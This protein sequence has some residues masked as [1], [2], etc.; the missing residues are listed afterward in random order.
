M[1][2]TNTPPA[3]NVT[4]S[5]AA[6]Q[7]AVLTALGTLTD[8]DGLGPLSWNWQRQTGS[9]WA[10]VDGA[11]D[12]TYA[13][14][15]ADV[16]HAVRAIASYTD[17][18]GTA[19]AVTSDPTAVVANVNDAPTGEVA[20]S[21]T[22][23]L[24]GS[25]LS[26][27]A[28]LQ[29]TDGLGPITFV[30]Q[31]SDDAGGWTTIVAAA[32]PNYTPVQADV[33][34]SLRVLATY[35]DGQG[36]AESVASSATAVV[37]N[38]N[39]LPTGTLT[40][41]GIAKQGLALTIN[42]TLA[43]PDGLG[44]VAYRWQRDGGVAGWQDIAN[45]TA[46]S[47]T[48]AQADVGHALRAVAS[49]TDAYGTG[50]SVVSTA[51]PP[52]ANVND[53]PT[54]T[55][56]LA[57]TPKQNQPLTVQDTLDDVDGLGDRLYVWQRSNSTGGWTTI[58][59][60]AGPAYT[61]TQADVGLRLRAV[62]SYTDG[63][64]TGE[65]VASPATVA[66]VNDNDL[67]TGSVT[68]AGTASQGQ[69]L[70]ASN[71]LAD[72]DGLGTVNYTWQ[73]Y[74]GASWSSIAGATSARYTPVQADV[75]HYVRAVASY[76]DGL[77]TTEQVASDATDFVANV[78]DP[79]TGSIVV[80]GNPIQ[81]ARLTAAISLAD[82]DGFGAYATRWQRLD[83]L[84][85][86]LDIPGATGAGYALT[87][88]DVGLQ[89]RVQVSFTDFLGTD[90]SLA[91]AP[92]SAVANLNDL[93]AG[94]ITIDGI[95]LQGRALV[96]SD[97]LNDPDGVTDFNYV[98]QRSMPGGWS[99]IAGATTDTYVPGAADQ[100]ATLRVVISYTDLQG[101]AESVT[102][103]PT[104]QVLAPSDLPPGAMAAIGLFDAAHYLAQNADVA[105]AGV[106][107]FQHYMTSGWREG[108]DPSALFRT[109]FYLN[110]NPDVAAA[111]INPLQH[112][113][114]AGWREGRDPS[115][116]FSASRYLEAYTDVRAAGLNPL[117]HY[118]QSGRAERRS[119]FPAAPHPT[120]P[121]DPLVDAAFY[122][123]AHP[124]VAADGTDAAASYHTAGWRAGWDP[125]PWFHT[126]YYL[127]QNP[128]IRAAGVDPLAHFEASGWREGR[129]P[130][131]GFSLSGYLT[132]N[133][134][135]AA[136]GLDPLS[137]YVVSGRFEGRHTIAATPRPTGPQDPLI[138]A[139][140]YYAQHPLAA[141]A[142]LDATA[143]YNA[144]GWRTGGSPNAWF[145]SNF[146]LTQYTDVAAAGID[147][148]AHYASNGWREGRIPS[149]LFDP[150][151]YL[152]ANPDVAAAGLEP[153]THFMTSG[154]NEG[155]A[156]LLP[157]G[158]APSD[159]LVDPTFYGRQLGAQLIPDGQA[160]Q[161]QAAW[162]YDTQGWQRG[163]DPDAWFDTSYY[164]SHNPDVA[165][166]HINPLLHY[167]NSGWRE[168]RN[169]SAAFSTN[170]YL[171]AHPDVR[172]ASLNPLLHYVVSGQHE[173]RITVPV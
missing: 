1:P 88:A 11:T 145:D 18:L 154:N 160:G 38:V 27:T 77:G 61:P 162:S 155:R 123:A 118:M 57:G 134:D 49:Y 142:G 124:G 109:R 108:R 83:A 85:G 173:G 113:A 21:G 96:A 92:T 164:L 168:G 128:D 115:V 43:D 10:A 104:A 135:V 129:D 68:L 71:S 136:A 126:E 34:R 99:T 53:A 14:T 146:Y 24:Q 52:V 50:E 140:R 125:N 114:E 31:R 54:G 166:A 90:E 89:L 26:A 32:S 35:T 78:N 59:S 139:A 58:P 172:G 8:E 15:Q 39:D 41:P 165:A 143:D 127:N 56:L 101:T 170:G 4:L 94:T 111:G 106:N 70:T 117:Q 69:P 100:G 112:F 73:R 75:G 40:I 20:I 48:P 76:L 5:G 103:A 121:Q 36:T 66:V 47:Y 29:D 157:G 171:N 150:R 119:A 22:A 42:G 9:T 46:A 44:P 84:A 98:W 132:A 74:L 144:G 37:G 158:S 62:A 23:S 30:W 151:A 149:L 148:L 12:Q 147:P 116:A 133:P 17:G 159:P 93:P 33:S 79:A 45:A 138:D 152:T 122:Y 161:Q 65:S 72:S 110:Q 130:S 167:E 51:T 81:D 120:G 2:S 3:G 55:L 102:S 6:T 82:P 105:A 156:A 28:M 107:P 19:E 95:P 63:L 16:G 67:P 141:A 153:L 86:W 25:P 169:P 137:H 163:L 131:I 87:Q 97:T 13:L 60:A 64:G 80:S 7:R 91:S